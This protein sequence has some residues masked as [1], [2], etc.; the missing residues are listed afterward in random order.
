MTIPKAIVHSFGAVT[1]SWCGL[2]LRVFAWGLAVGVPA[3]VCL[4][5]T[6]GASQAGCKNDAITYAKA[7]WPEGKCDAISTASGCGRPD[8]QDTA[9]CSVGERRIRCTSS[10]GE[11]ICTEIIK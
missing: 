2:V 6:V 7:V 1:R 4:G 8:A 11:T 5:L 10:D 9:V 3:S